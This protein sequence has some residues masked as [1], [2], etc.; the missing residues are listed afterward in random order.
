MPGIEQV[1]LGVNTRNERARNLYESLG[2]EA[3]GI[4]R[5]ALQIDGE[6][7]DTELMSLRL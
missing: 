5:R 6:Y 1:H 7:F 3:Y 4:E 2:F